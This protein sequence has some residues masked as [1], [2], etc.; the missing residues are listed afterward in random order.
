MYKP[1][2]NPV[3]RPLSYTREKSDAILA[4]IQTGKW[5]VADAAIACGI[6]PSTFFAWVLADHDGIYDRYAHAEQLRMLI[7]RDQILPILDDGHNDWQEGKFGP[8]VNPEVVKRSVERAKYRQYLTE[9]HLPARLGGKAGVSAG[10]A[11]QV[12][13]DNADTQI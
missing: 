10:G 7:L 13:L 6:K 3:G 2:G 11:V 8:R 4:L 9:T 12:V 1:T 5:S